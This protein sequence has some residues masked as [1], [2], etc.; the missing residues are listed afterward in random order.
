[1]L[2]RALPQNALDHLPRKAD[3]DCPQE[4]RWLYDRRNIKEAQS[5]LAAWLKRYPKLIDWAEEN[6]GETLIGAHN[7]ETGVV[8]TASS[9]S[10]ACCTRPQA[11]LA[12]L[13]LPPRDR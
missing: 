2:L 3:D 10:N 6:I 4:L 1:M 12:D 8:A 7:L 9:A 13:K 5:D 11:L